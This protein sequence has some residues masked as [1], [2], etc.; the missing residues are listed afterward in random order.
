MKKKLEIV[1]LTDKINA[2]DTLT[3]QFNR[4]AEWK[5][6]KGD[7]LIKEGESKGFNITLGDAG[8]YT[9]EVENYQIPIVVSSGFSLEFLSGLPITEIA[10]VI[11]LGLVGYFVYKKVWKKKKKTTKPDIGFYPNFKTPIEEA[12]GLKKK[13]D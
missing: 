3:V 2:G 6:L 5:L 4:E 12:V 8:N 9:L 1:E 10:I 13:E 11:V 7:K